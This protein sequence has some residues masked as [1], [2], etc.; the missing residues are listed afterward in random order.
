MSRLLD[1]AEICFL[2]EIMKYMFRCYRVRSIEGKSWAVEQI[3]MESRSS[4]I[5]LLYGFNY[6]TRTTC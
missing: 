5:A 4:R 2:V 3:C 1:V 6:M